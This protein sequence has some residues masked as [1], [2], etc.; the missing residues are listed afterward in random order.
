MHGLNNYPQCN[1]TS[2]QLVDKSCVFL[3][4]NK[5]HFPQIFTTRIFIT[6][7]IITKISFVLAQPTPRENAVGFEGILTNVTK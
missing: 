1:K 4:D 2:S 5:E 6:L 7:D 3:A